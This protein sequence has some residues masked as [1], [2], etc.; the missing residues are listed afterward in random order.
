[1]SGC[2]SVSPTR[3]PWREREVGRKGEGLS[4]HIVIPV[5]VCSWAMGQLWWMSSRITRSWR[6]VPCGVCPGGHCRVSEDDY[7]PGVLWPRSWGSWAGLKPG[8]LLE[9]L[10]GWAGREPEGLSPPGG[11]GG[12]ASLGAKPRMSLLTACV[13]MGLRFC[14][15]KMSGLDKLKSQFVAP[16]LWMV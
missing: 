4:K 3:A 16:T 6:W 5:P 7:R 9:T 10:S 15:S 1:M 11:L 13:S 2:V 14:I 8:K 12:G